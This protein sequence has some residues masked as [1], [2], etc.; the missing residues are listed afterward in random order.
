[1]STA[2]DKRIEE[3]SVAMLEACED[4]DLNQLELMNAVGS[5]TVGIFTTMASFA[6][7]RLAARPEQLAEFD[8]W[9]KYTRK[10][11]EESAQ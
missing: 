6:T 8:N 2:E 3:A 4:M 9:V 11:I 10:M 7:G 5:F 1:M